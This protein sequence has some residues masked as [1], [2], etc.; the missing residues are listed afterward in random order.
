MLE[1]IAGISREIVKYV[2]S[3]CRHCNTIAP[4]VDIGGVILILSFCPRERI[5]LD[6]MNFRVSFTLFFVYIKCTIANNFIV[7]P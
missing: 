6:L 2:L 1:F 7:S 4:Q 5:V 3:G